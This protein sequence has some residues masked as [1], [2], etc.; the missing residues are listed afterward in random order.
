MKP[1]QKQFLFW[2]FL[3]YLLTLAFGVVFFRGYLFPQGN[4]KAIDSEDKI[5]A[6]SKALFRKSLQAG[7]DMSVG[8]C[9]TN[10]LKP[11]WV[12]DI[13]HSPRQPIDNF[14]HYQCQAYLEGR[15][16]HI[17]EL[18]TAGNVVKVR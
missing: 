8:P 11:G 18:D 16:K 10:D 4:E 5:V 2:I 6:E 1:K 14:S 9:L 12:V 15:A 3:I 7:T 17:V 13:V